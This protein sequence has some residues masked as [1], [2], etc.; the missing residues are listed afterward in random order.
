MICDLISKEAFDQKWTPEPF[1]GCWLWTRG[2]TGGGYGTSYMNGNP[3]VAH[4]LSWI[5]YRGDIPAGMFVCH[6]C[7]I[8]LCVNP[9]HLFLGTQYDNML[10]A[11]R[12]KRLPRGKGE[13]NGQSKL[14]WVKAQFIRSSKQTNTELAR[15]FGVDRKTIRCVRN[16]TTWVVGE[17]Q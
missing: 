3:I 2:I 5:F 1:S 13:L 4:R 12:K 6:K 14:S 7:D 10:D 15:K 11:S 8:K 16:N 17:G 9:D